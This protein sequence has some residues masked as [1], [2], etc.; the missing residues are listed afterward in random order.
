MNIGDGEVG[1]DNDREAEFKLSEDILICSPGE[2]IDVVV[3]SI[4]M[5]ILKHFGDGLYFQDRVIL[6]PT[7]EIVQ[8]VNENIM[9]LL[10]GDITEFMSSNSICPDEDDIIN[11]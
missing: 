6:T 3:K 11:R 2:P 4:Y 10:P 9:S 7:N 5:R 1:D 8:E